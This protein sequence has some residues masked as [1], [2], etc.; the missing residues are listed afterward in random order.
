MRYPLNRIQNNNHKVGTYKTN[1]ISL[2]NLDEKILVL[3][4]GFEALALGS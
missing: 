1:K 3:D 4:I 2:P